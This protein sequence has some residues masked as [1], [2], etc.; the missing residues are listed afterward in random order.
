MKAARESKSEPELNAELKRDD[1][2]EPTAESKPKEEDVDTKKPFVSADFLL[3]SIRS[4]MIMRREY[5]YAFTRNPFSTAQM[6]TLLLH[7]AN[8][9]WDM[10]YHFSL[11]NTAGRFE[12][13][14]FKNACAWKSVK[15]TDVHGVSSRCLADCITHVARSCGDVWFSFR[16]NPFSVVEMDHILLELSR[17][18]QR[19]VDVTSADG[20]FVLSISSRR[21]GAVGPRGPGVNEYRLTIES[22]DAKDWKEQDRQTEDSDAQRQEPA[23]MTYYLDPI[24]LVAAFIGLIAMRG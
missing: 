2:K 24:L 18:P 22:D 15:V 8:T 14:L 21:T 13:R 3:Q 16:S 10:N 11:Q 7:V 4:A 1:K 17:I 5:I 6:E 9:D 12:L 20:V 23:Q 19:G